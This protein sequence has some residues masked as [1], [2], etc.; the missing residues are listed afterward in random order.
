VL[1]RGYTSD[2]SSFR[3]SQEKS[4]GF[5]EGERC[6]VFIKLTSEYF[7]YILI[8][9]LLSLWSLWFALFS[10][11]CF[12]LFFCLGLWSLV[13]T[14]PSSYLN[15]ITHLCMQGSRKISLILNQIQVF[16]ENLANEIVRYHISNPVQASYSP[17]GPSCIATDDSLVSFS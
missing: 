15:K 8:P 14:S 11:F 7:I 3:P 16:F 6:S 9:S 12:Y 5:R 1:E 10:S 17:M 13:I 4:V 2:A